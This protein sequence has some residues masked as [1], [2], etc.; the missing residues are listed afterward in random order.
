VS[1]PS[2]W[3][4]WEGP[5]GEQTALIEAPTRDMAVEKFAE[6]MSL[7]SGPQK[8]LIQEWQPVSITVALRY[9]VIG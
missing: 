9:R 7:P 3:C 6:Q 5:G 2:Y 1:F 8:V 4:I